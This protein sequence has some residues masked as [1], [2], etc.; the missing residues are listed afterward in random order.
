LPSGKKTVLDFGPQHV[1]GRTSERAHN[2]RLI[3][4][5][6]ETH[7]KLLHRSNTFVSFSKRLPVLSFQADLVE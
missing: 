5:K 3:V 2:K 7:W 1:Q 6:I 4:S